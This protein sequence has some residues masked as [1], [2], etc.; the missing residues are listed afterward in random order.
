MNLAK[1]AIDVPA[2]QSVQLTKVFGD[3]R[4]VDG[5]DLR[6][7]RGE[8]F[9]FCGPNGSG[10][11]TTIKILLDEL[12]PTS[13]SAQIFGLDTH[14][15]A[16]AVHALVGYLPGDLVLP[17]DMKAGA[18]LD[19]LASL[20][21]AC[22]QRFRDT[23]VDRFELDL[24]RRI[25]DLSTGNRQK[26][27]LVQAFMHRPALVLLDEP[28]TGLD[29]LVQH[30]F[31]ELLNE[32]TADGM[33]VLLST[34][35]LSELNRV[36]QRVGI[37]RQGRLVAV[38]RVA[39]LRST[40]RSRLEFEF[41]APADLGFLR[42]ADGIVDLQITGNTVIAIVEGAIDDTLRRATDTGTIVS[43][44]APETDLQQAFLDHYS[45]PATPL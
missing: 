21:Q 28:M 24:T 43:I 29:P 2:I 23:L 34:H 10:K 36:A 44:R 17:G 8:I 11:S 22:D 45:K 9:G 32:V 30:S 1:P 20:R 35:R 5:V 33:T 12:R 19:F 27:G 42:S 15:R 4:A 7:E 16:R 40:T 37:L 25:G 38:D 26:V 13:G 39:E 41:A 31:H 18:Y 6:V 3:L 14:S